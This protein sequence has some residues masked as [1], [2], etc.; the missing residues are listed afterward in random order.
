[1]GQTKGQTYLTTFIKIKGVET[2]V[3]YLAQVKPIL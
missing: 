2:K 1:M 3:G